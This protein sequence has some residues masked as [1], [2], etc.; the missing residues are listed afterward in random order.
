MITRMMTQTVLYQV[1]RF[2]LQGYARLMLAM[3][4]VH[5]APLPDGPKII[6]PNHP[7]TVDPFLVTMLCTEQVHILV[8]ESAFKVPL[9]GRYLR[10]AGH[11]PVVTGEGRKAFE[12]AQQLLLEGHTIA[13]FPEGALSPVGGHCRPH[14]GVARLALMTGAAV[15]PVGIALQTERIRLLHTGIVNGGG[16]EEVARLY[17]RGAYAITSGT[18]IQLTGD[19]EDRQRVALLS[20]Q[21]MQHIKRLSKHSAYRIDARTRPVCDTAEMPRI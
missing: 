21:I 3:D 6:A 19:V 17:T 1:G 13:I 5:Q 14:T 2:A 11:I 20:E 7:T 16:Q 18:P 10:R 4:I 8:T 12:T 15:I 9:F